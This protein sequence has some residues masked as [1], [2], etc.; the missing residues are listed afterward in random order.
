MYVFIDTETTGLPRRWN[1][2]PE[3]I[4]NWPRLVQIG[5]ARYDARNRH[6]GT[7]AFIVKPDGF[8]IPPDAQRV[9]GI[10][11]ERALAEGAEL[12]V[13][14][15]ALAQAMQRATVVVAHNLRFDENVI[16]A[17]FLRQ[18]RPNP[19]LGK[20]RLCTMTAT[21]EFCR[22]PGPRGHKWPTL[23][24]LHFAVFGTLPAETHDARADVTTCAK[25]FFALKKRGVLA[26]G[27]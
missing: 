7:K 1:A 6:L 12:K 11:T 21:T 17:E 5:W 10:S 15:D 14:L 4:D 8:S 22:L 27:S 24:E 2:P 25:C 20:A 19:F 9:H 23:E 18:G 26:V 3:D 16:A 13:V